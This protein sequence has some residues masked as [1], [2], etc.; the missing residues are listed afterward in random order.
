MDLEY[1][2]SV[3]GD[4]CGGVFPYKTSLG[5]CAKCKKLADL[6]PGSAEHQSWK[7][8]KQCTGCGV[9]W[10]N[11]QG[12]VCGRC[13]ALG[14][15]GLA[16]NGGY[17][18]FIHLNYIDRLAKSAI[19]ASRNARANAMD[20]RMNKQPSAHPL[21]T[22]AGL[23]NAKSNN[24]PTGENKIFISVG[25]RIK[26]SSKRGQGGTDPD[27]GSWGKPWAKEDYLSEVLDDAL[28]T[29]N[30]HWAKTH[31]MPLQRSE[32]DFRW[33]GNKLFLPGTSNNTIGAVYKEYQTGEMAAYY[34][35]N[36]AKVK[37]ALKN[38]LS[39]ALELYVNQPAA[40]AFMDSAPQGPQGR[41][42]S[43]TST[44]LAEEPAPINKRLVAVGAGEQ[45]R[46]RFIRTN[47][48]VSDGISNSATSIRLTRA[49]TTCDV[50][51]GQV[52]TAWPDDAE[53]LNGFIGKSKLATGATKE[54]Y[55]L[56]IGSTLYVAKRFF[57]IGDG[58][59]DVSAADNKK[60]LMSELDRLKMTAWFLRN[61]KS[62]AKQNNVEI[63]TGI[64]VSDGF[65]VRKLGSPSP[66]SGLP[67]MEFDKAVW[68]VEPRRTTSVQKFSGTLAHPNREDELGLT[69]IAFTHFIYDTSDKE[70]V[71]A[72]IQG[73]PMS[74]DKRDVMVLFDLMSHTPASD[75]GIGDH[76]PA[77]IQAFLSQH[78]CNHIC[79]GLELSAITH[80]APDGVEGD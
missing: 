64:D 60:Y 1:C 79:R 68:L 17:T 14:K 38:Q 19:E 12:T 48:S 22:T 63:S 47:R 7:E 49:H 33:A 16:Q 23:S 34:S 43:A 18:F 32:V 65:L 36:D 24:T 61:F 70:L 72:D 9:A 39:M 59:D 71:L 67:P 50:E 46:S 74:I 73:S 6:E 26:S 37:K 45:P 76:G 41:K 80:E 10:K 55:Q 56:S 78:Q 20:A 30:A 29:L 62:H 66:A 2:E 35:P 40:G 8:M 21:H 53:V 75:S 4:A 44:S 5:L 31:G 69:L 51:T 3:N 77:G 54:V 25:C 11:L 15:S 27:C 57:E 28:N 13:S 52:D 42:R 58:K